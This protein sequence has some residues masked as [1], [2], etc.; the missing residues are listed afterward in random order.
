[1]QKWSRISNSSYIANEYRVEGD[2]AYIKLR[3][4]VHDAEVRIDLADLE[5]VLASGSWNVSAPKSQYRYAIAYARNEEGRDTKMYLHRFLVGAVKGD[6][7]DHL[8]GD[9]LDC[10]RSNLK[11]TTQTDNL[12][13]TWRKRILECDSCKLCSTHE[14]PYLV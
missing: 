4:R 10:R 14:T 6:Y 11:L 12:R 9:T 5:R 7:V 2:I 13:N 8:N 1:M 3:S